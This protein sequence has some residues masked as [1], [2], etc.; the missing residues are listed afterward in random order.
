MT[1]PVKWPTLNC[2]AS[3]SQSLFFSSILCLPPQKKNLNANIDTHTAVNS[4]CG[5]LFSS[6]KLSFWTQYHDHWGFFL[7]ASFVNMFCHLNWHCDYCSSVKSLDKECILFYVYC[8]LWLKTSKSAKSDPWSTSCIYEVWSQDWS[9][10][11]TSDQATN[12]L[13]DHLSPSPRAGC[14]SGL[15][16]YISTISHNQQIYT[17]AYKG[18]I[19]LY[20]FISQTHKVKVNKEN[21]CS[22][23]SH[24]TAKLEKMC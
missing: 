9:H 3:L 15:E 10:T 5:R 19:C 11:V 17:E 4:A 18:N 12:L 16:L 1:S 22:D 23:D 21:K 8:Y 6:P 24:P 14:I 20:Y 2:G 13:C 7:S